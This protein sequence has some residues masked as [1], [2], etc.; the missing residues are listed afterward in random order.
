MKIIRINE[1]CQPGVTAKILRHCELCQEA[2][3]IKELSVNYGFLNRV[4]I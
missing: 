4:C 2:A 1:K 3:V